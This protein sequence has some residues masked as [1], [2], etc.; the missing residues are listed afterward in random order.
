MKRGVVRS[1]EVLRDAARNFLADNCLDHAAAIAYYTL[2]SL[3]PF[4]YLMGVLGRSLLPGGDATGEALDRAAAFLPLELAPALVWLRE[5]L[6]VGEALVALA[7][8][9]LLWVSISAFASL[10]Y[11]VNV[12]FGTVPRRRFWLSTLKAFAGAA[13]VVVVLV[14]SLVASHTVT[15]LEARRMQPGLPAI[16]GAQAAWASRALLLGLTFGGF[17]TLYKILPRGRV[18]WGAA[19][20]GATVALVMWEA[21]RRLFG[22]LLLGSPALGV[23]GGALAAVV[24]FLLWIYTAAA[25]TLLG[26]ELAACLN[27]N[28]GRRGGPSGGGLQGNAA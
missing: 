19:G 25:V 23:I 22:A 5:N 8:P 27:G 26:A 24:S 3:G 18:S 11:A 4:V 1:L 15:W 2:L 10:E 28:R 13:C 21:A 17:L 9:A 6:R 14:V 12:A 16:V 20:A 7:I